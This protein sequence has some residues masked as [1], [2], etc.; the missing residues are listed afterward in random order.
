MYISSNHLSHVFG[1]FKEMDLLHTVLFIQK[2][3]LHYKIP[4]SSLSQE[5]RVDRNKR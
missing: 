4:N 2:V 1:N 5:K 3:S